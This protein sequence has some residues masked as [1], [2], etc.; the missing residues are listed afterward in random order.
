MF[1]ALCIAEYIFI[2]R[3]TTDIRCNDECNVVRPKQR[4]HLYSLI[5][6]RFKMSLFGL[7][8]YVPVVGTV[9]NTLEGVGAVLLG[10]THRAAEKLTSA[11]VG[12]ALDILTFGEG[13]SIFKLRAKQR[14]KIAVKKGV[15]ITTTQVAVNA[16]GR[17]VCNAALRNGRNHRGNHMP[18]EHLAASRYQ[19]R[20]FWG[21][22]DDDDE[23]RN[24]QNQRPSK[25]GARTCNK[26]QR[27]ECLQRYSEN[28]CKRRDG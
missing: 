20:F 14:I 7:L 3:L 1:K 17:I 8:D 26:Q 28:L 24:S 11:A 10:D 6:C 21:E 27:V 23:R 25:R 2:N 4:W 22:D 12:G 9:K 19:N 15:Q 16:G 5:F 18:Y 13:S